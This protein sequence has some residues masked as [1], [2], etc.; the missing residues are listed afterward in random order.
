LAIYDNLFA[1]DDKY[2]MDEHVKRREIKVNNGKSAEKKQKDRE[3][4]SE[5]RR[6]QKRPV[7]IKCNIKDDEG[8]VNEES[9]QEWSQS[10][11]Q[12]KEERAEKQKMTED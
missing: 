5:C 12:R 3:S 4:G 10:K 9:K 1:N 8:K 6:Q 7:Q 2:E 11:N